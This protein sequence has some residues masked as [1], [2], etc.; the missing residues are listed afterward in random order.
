MKIIHEGNRQLEIYKVPLY[1][2]FTFPPDVPYQV[3]LFYNHI[4]LLLKRIFVFLL[5]SVKRLT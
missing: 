4:F 2:F 5:H 3:E 1:F